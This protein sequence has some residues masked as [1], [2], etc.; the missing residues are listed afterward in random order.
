M[1]ANINEIKLVPLNMSHASHFYKWWNDKEL[2]ALT[3]Q[4]VEEEFVELDKVTQAINYRLFSS[5]NLYF[6]I[7]F[8]KKVIGSIEVET[9]ED[10][11][12]ENLLMMKYKT[13]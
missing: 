7:E 9:I 6:V 8:D 3:S 13:I 5:P 11:G 10:K 2:R 12:K 4:I 1:Q